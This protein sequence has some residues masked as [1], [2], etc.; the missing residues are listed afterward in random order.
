MKDFKLN[1]IHLCD[2]ALFSQDGKLSLI[3]IFEII[4]VI[5][6]PSSLSRASLVFN[7]NVLNKNLNKVDLD[8][9][10]RNSDSGEETFKLPTLTPS[11]TRNPKGDSND[12]EVKL[13]IALKLENI[14]FKKTGKYAID[15]KAN[16]MAV[17]SLNF[18]VKLL[19]Q[20]KG[21]N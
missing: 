1:F 17:G 6:L 20:N 10:I 14:L 8:I 21:A 7:M 9:T 4:N 16:S 3:G 2:E 13:G 12:G 15:L 5:N 18:H 11:F 19:P